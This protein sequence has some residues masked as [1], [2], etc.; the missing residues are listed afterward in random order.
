MIGEYAKECHV[1]YLKSIE[2]RLS[3]LRE[4]VAKTSENENTF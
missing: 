1:I 3:K 2:N 4:D